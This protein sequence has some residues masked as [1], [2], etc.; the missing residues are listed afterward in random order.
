[1]R[2]R[3]KIGLLDHG[4]DM[5][6]GKLIELIKDENQLSHLKAEPGFGISFSYFMFFVLVKKD[7]NFFYNI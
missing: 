5:G 1:M 4:F 3:V 2:K 7:R 6:G